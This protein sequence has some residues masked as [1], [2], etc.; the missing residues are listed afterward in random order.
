VDLTPALLGRLGTWPVLWWCRFRPAGAVPSDLFGHGLAEV[1]LQV[2]SISDLHGVRQRSADRFGVG[3][4]AVPAHHLDARMGTKPRL[5][6]V[7]GA[8]LEDVDT[9]TGLRIDEHSGVPTSLT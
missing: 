3:G 1:V 4:G 6:A 9:A 7:S 2:P 5:Q 8:I